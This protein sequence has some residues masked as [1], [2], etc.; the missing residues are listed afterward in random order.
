MVPSTVSEIT[1][2][3]SFDIHFRIVAASEMFGFHVLL[4]KCKILQTPRKL[5]ISS[6]RSCLKRIFFGLDVGCPV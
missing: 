6:S 5:K 1:D 3:V 4:A 2:I